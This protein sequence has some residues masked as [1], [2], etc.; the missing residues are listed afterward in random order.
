MRVTTAVETFALRLRALLPL[1]L[2]TLALGACTTGRDMSFKL[3]QLAPRD[4]DCRVAHDCPSVVVARGEFTRT[5]ANDFVAFVQT[6]ARQPG[7]KNVVL[8]DS[9]GG[10]V[11]GSLGLGLV[12]RRLGSTVIIG[13]PAGD[14]PTV[15]ALRPGLCTSGCA[16]AI[17]GAK[18][19]L[20]V[21]GSRIGVHQVH[22]R[23]DLGEITP[24]SAGGFVTLPRDATELQIL[25]AYA[26]LM[27]VDPRVIDLS[28]SVPPSEIRY[29]EPNELNRFRMPVRTLRN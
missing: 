1:L 18:D 14:G 3:V 22:R 27:G 20:A 7:V 26:K 11:G 2:V 28:E 23:P 16:F 19:R 5:T 8:I 29:L 15:N 13:R 4:V 9:P 10:N 12:L 6:E 25:K 24:A 17:M 21:G